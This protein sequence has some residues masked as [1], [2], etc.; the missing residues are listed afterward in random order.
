M[1][2]EVAFP[3]GWNQPASHNVLGLMTGCMARLVAGAS[4]RI[5]YSTTAWLPQLERFAGRAEKTWLPVPSNLSE[6]VE[7]CAVARAR[8]RLS[9]HP[10]SAVVGHF[11]TYSPKGHGLLMD[12]FASVLDSDGGNTALFAGRGSIAFRD[13]FIGRMPSQ[14]HRVHAIETACP[15]TLSAHLAACD[16]LVQPYPDGV[17]TRRASLM[18][19][20]AL[21]KAIVTNS[22]RLTE[23]L[24]KESATVALVE[25]LSPQ[26]I[27]HSVLELLGS[28]ARRSQL[29]FRAAALYAD[30]FA[31]SHT[32]KALA[33]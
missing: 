12:V 33:S 3:L 4:E 30:R 17:T 2:H 26:A 10:G 32:L 15:K 19:S 18:A 13:G 9:G 11:G 27:A 31:L 6:T 5:F 24:W 28:D 25:G 1:F 21:G 22:G 16:V 14:A 29:G 23:A 20:L 7:E 8:A